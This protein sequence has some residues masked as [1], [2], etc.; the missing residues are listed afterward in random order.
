MMRVYPGKTDE[1]FPQDKVRGTILVT[2]RRLDQEGRTYFYLEHPVKIDG[3]V[4]KYSK[5]LGKAIPE[6][7]DDLKKQFLFEINSSRWAAV[8]ELAKEKMESLKK[9]LSSEQIEMMQHNSALSFTANS[10]MIS[11]SKITMLE[12]KR[13]IEESKVP[14]WRTSG[15][16]KEA[17]AHYEIARDNY[18][19]TQEF[20]FDLMVDWHWKI[21]RESRPSIAGIVKGIVTAAR[22][23]ESYY[24]ENSRK[25][26][27]TMLGALI[28]WKLTREKPFLEG[29][30]IIARLSM[31]WLLQMCGYP[32]L[33][34]EFNERK[35]YES[36]LQRSI[37]QN[38]ESIFLK[39]FFLKYERKI[40]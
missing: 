31:N 12:L 18:K 33:D 15:E 32:I 1:L 21:F 7:V 11:G 38:D 2:I 4:K 30:D 29:D 16:I 40:C 9:G 25:V 19:R 14:K 23:I 27:K 36:A 5:Y 10:L 3:R 37:L 34:L 8:S 17:K 39:W 20:S 22:E 28:H 24:D 35:R 6:N 26:E 13:L